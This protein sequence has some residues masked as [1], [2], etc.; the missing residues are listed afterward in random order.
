MTIQTKGNKM[1]LELCFADVCLSC[2]WSGSNKMHLQVPVYKGMTLEEIK[3]GLRYEVAAGAIGGGD[4]LADS[5]RDDCPQVY[6][7]LENAIENLE[8]S[9]QKQETFFNDLEEEDDA[10]D[11]SMTV[12]AF[13]IVDEV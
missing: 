12:Y 8:P 1:N 11:S 13:F 9:N 10:D 7:A 2:Y 3:D 5:F 4:S 6:Q